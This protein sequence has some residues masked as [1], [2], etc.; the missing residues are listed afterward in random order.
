M[1]RIDDRTGSIELLPLL[2][3]LGAP[4]L[5]HRL[6]FA[7]ARFKGNGPDGPVRIGIERKTIDEIVSAME[8][9][10]FVGHQLPGLLARFDWVVLIVEGR[11]Y[12]DVRSGVLM[13]SRHQVGRTKQRHL[14]E[15]VEKFL[16]T[17]RF[18]ARL[19]II[20]TS[21]LVHT[22]YAIKAL[23]DWSGKE[24][25]AHKSAY[26]VDEA[27]ADT[28]I[29][30]ARTVK[31]KV[32][33]Q[34][35]GVGWKR[36]A[37]AGMLFPTIAAAIRGDLGYTLTR[38]ERRRQ[39]LVWRGVTWRSGNGKRMTIGPKTAARIVQVLHEREPETAKGH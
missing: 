20:Q 3:R 17:L 9:S 38:D 30:T 39:E 18:K 33:A 5:K 26:R 6:D 27:R 8:D 4:V 31:R 32:L 29:L 28:A 35:P 23:Y 13:N 37:A 34:V 10:R 14:Y 15:N 21:S 36:S 25:H 24:W 16:C 11:W 12:P 1:I 22:A 7:D 2:R 19:Q